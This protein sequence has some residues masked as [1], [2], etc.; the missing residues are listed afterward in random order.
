MVSFSFKKDERLCSQKLIGGIFLSGRSFNCYPLKIAW[1]NTDTLDSSY[2]AQA[3]FSVPKKNFKKAHDRNLI[4]R[5]M[6]ESWRFHK[7]SLYEYLGGNETKIA[8][9]IIFIGKEDQEF[10]KIESAMVKGLDRLQQEI[11]SEK[12]RAAT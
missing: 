7:S 8:L 2:P 9:V 12:I 1:I 3:A 6:R 4:R 5:K 10:R 11:L